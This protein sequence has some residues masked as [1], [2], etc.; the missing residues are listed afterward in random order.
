MNLEASSGQMNSIPVDTAVGA[1]VTI[2][3]F[4]VICIGMLI[5][6]TL[7]ICSEH[8]FSMPTLSFTYKAGIHIGGYAHGR[9]GVFKLQN[10]PL[11][12]WHVLNCSSEISTALVSSS[13]IHKYL[14][15]MV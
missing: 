6:L 13:V 5:L 7:L 9:R 10:C 15:F 3:T 4:G 8:P 12:F 1:E 2:Q 14:L 11:A